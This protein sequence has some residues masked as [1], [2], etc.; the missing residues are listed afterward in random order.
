MP[1]DTDTP[2]GGSY[3]DEFGSTKNPYNRG[4]YGGG[5]TD[6][7]GSTA[8][9]YTNYGGYNLGGTFGTAS[10]GS[11]STGSG[12]TDLFGTPFGGTPTS[13]GSAGGG[14]T[15]VGGGS[16]GS[17]TTTHTPTQPMPVLGTTTPYK[18]PEWD[19]KKKG[20]MAQRDAALGLSETRDA[21]LTATNK[22]TAIGGG[23]ITAQAQCVKTA[24]SGLGN[25]IA[26]VMQTAD[27]SALAEY[28]QMH[29]DLIQEAM[30]NF[31][32]AQ[33]AVYAKYQADMAAW[34]AT[35]T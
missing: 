3:V 18:N 8:N 1:D 32:A 19:E 31:N 21:F 10:P 16:T 11:T 29:S 25:S 28:T 4:G 7:F 6:E 15:R 22:C 24:M 12:L 5:F 27:K 26:K 34:M 33:Q 30:Y 14:T 13:G 17:S 23:N 20:A 9:P 2:S 35:L